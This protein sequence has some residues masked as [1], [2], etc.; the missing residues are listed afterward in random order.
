MCILDVFEMKNKKLTKQ[1]EKKVFSSAVFR[2]K[3]AKQIDCF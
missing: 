1:T 3:L 2:L